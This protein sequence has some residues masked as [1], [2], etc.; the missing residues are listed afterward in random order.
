MGI[1]VKELRI[2][3]YVHAFGTNPGMVDELHKSHLYI[4]WVDSTVTYS[5]DELRPIPLTEDWLKKFGFKFHN[6]YRLSNYTGGTWLLPYN[7]TFEIFW[8]K[9]YGFY[10]EFYRAC[11]RNK[12]KYVHSLQ[13]LYFV[14]TGKE[15]KL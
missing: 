12:I 8:E 3:N 2:G 1:S 14:L 6:W 13:N 5:Y 10:H 11:K 7:R 15:L 4:A 9:K